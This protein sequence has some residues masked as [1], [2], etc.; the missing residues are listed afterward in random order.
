MPLFFI[1]NIIIILSQRC[2]GTYTVIII[3]IIIK[4][5]IRLHIARVIMI[6][7]MITLEMIQFAVLGLPPKFHNYF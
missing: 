4:F 2:L 5:L 7:I 3:I 6:D 1:Q